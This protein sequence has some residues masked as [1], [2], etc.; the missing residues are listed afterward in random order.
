LNYHDSRKSK[1][2]SQCILLQF[3]PAEARKNQI[4]CRHIPLNERGET[5]E[6]LYR[7]GTQ[8]ELESAVRSWLVREIEDLEKAD[9]QEAVSK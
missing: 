9:A 4:P 6:S 1:P 3:V 2:C 8:E 5:I 7:T